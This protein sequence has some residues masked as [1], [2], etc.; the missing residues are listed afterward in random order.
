MTPIQSPFG[1]AILFQDNDFN[2]LSPHGYHHIYKLYDRNNLKDRWLVA[3]IDADIPRLVVVHIAEKIA[4]E[5]ECTYVTEL[6]LRKQKDS[7]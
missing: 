1:I 4:D 2:G 3:T 6:V 7:L 5:Y